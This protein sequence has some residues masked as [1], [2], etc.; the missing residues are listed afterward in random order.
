[1][2]LFF[3]FKVFCKSRPS[4]WAPILEWAGNDQQL[5]KPVGLL[6]DLFEDHAGCVEP[7]LERGYC[8]LLGVK[9]WE[10]LRLVKSSIRQLEYLSSLK[11]TGHSTEIEKMFTAFVEFVKTSSVGAEV[12]KSLPSNWLYCHDNEK[13]RFLGKDSLAMKVE[14]PVFPEL[15]GLPWIYKKDKLA[16]NFFKRSVC[17]ITSFH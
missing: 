17:F 16:T 7:V 8:D 1:L 11:E 5:V 6:S 13:A 15:F 9:A 14:N 4:Y 12:Y 3:T 2:S 10:S